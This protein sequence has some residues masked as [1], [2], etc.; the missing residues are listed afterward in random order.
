M[1][2]Q[3]P[4]HLTAFG[5]LHV[6]APAVGITVHGLN[7]GFDVGVDKG[8]IQQQCRGLNAA[9]V[10]DAVVIQRW[11]RDAHLPFR[12]LSK[13]SIMPSCMVIHTGLPAP[14]AFLCMKFNCMPACCGA[15]VIGREFWKRTLSCSK[16]R[17]RTSFPWVLSAAG[18]FESLS[19]VP[20][21]SPGPRPPGAMLLRPAE[22]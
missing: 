8:R 4:D 17:M 12:F 16:L 14:C 18:T 7:G 6:W 19:S 3:P 5:C 10:A 11:K 9:K 1:G 2:N 22:A 15:F 20:N 21:P 13:N